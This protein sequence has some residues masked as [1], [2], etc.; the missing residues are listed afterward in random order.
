MVL[1]PD[2]IEMV[3]RLAAREERSRAKMIE[4]A[5]RRLAEKE[6]AAA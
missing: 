5:I 6:E 1:P 3:D 4:I 2:V